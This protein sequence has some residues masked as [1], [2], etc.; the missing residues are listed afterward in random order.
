MELLQTLAPAVAAER[1][2]ADSINTRPCPPLL[3]GRPFPSR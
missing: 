2:D 3:P 1:G